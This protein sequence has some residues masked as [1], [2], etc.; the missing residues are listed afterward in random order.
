VVPD[1]PPETA[2]AAWVSLCTV[3]WPRPLEGSNNAVLCCLLLLLPVH[4]LSSVAWPCPPECSSDA[5]GPVLT[6]VIDSCW[7]AVG[8]SFAALVLVCQDDPA[9]VLFWRAQ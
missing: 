1:A 8:P 3:A 9:C 4:L 7:G 2:A 6:A 5:V